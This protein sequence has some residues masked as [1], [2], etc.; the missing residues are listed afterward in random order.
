MT[1]EKRI[2]IEKKSK[3]M[4]TEENKVDKTGEKRSK[5]GGANETTI[6]ERERKKGGKSHVIR[7][8]TIGLGIK[9]KT[10]KSMRD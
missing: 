4:R 3:S 1:G 5:T 10:H 6:Q 9:E 8:L 2:K 7:K